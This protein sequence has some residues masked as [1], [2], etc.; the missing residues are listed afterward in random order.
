MSQSR[1][2]DRV[3]GFGRE[4]GARMSVSSGPGADCSALINVR[5]SGTHLAD[6]DG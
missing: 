2:P 5:E 4:N 3:Y 6:A 1:S